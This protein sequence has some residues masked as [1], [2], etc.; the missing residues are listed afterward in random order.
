[1]FIVATCLVQNALIAVLRQF[2]G[3]YTQTYSKEKHNRI[4]RTIGKFILAFHRLIY[5]E[6]MDSC[7]LVPHFSPII[8]QGTET[9]FDLENK[10]YCV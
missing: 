7:F 6:K 3:G 4:Y 9:C 2:Y 10:C 1:M 8:A 5:I